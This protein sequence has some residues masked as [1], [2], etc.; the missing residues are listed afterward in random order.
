MR[1]EEHAAGLDKGGKEMGFAVPAPST[2]E[3]PLLDVASQR[4][5][6]FEH[7]HPTVLNEN[8]VLCTLH[9]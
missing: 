3:Y 7:R 5:R 8:A 6:A 2:G 9:F 1:Q 4:D